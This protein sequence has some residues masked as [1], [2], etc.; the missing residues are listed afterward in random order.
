MAIESTMQ[1]L[2]AS[3]ALLLTAFFAVAGA[4]HHHELPRSSHDH[5]GFCSAPSAPIALES[6]ALC[7]VAHTAVQ[8]AGDAVATFTLDGTTPLVLA[9]ID[10]P[11]SAARSLPGDPRAP[12]VL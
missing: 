6:C 12:P 5:A 9:A 4:F 10:T 11:S 2:K 3:A 7:R 1:R 8:L